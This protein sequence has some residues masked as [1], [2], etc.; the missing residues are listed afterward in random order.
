MHP[1]LWRGEMIIRP[2]PA[3]AQFVFEKGLCS[4]R[5][6]F[7]KRLSISRKGLGGS[8]VR[9]Y[10]DLGSVQSVEHPLIS[11]NIAINYYVESFGKNARYVFRPCFNPGW[12]L[13]GLC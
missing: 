7:D 1:S 6:L 4:I 8:F 3:K 10:A 13:A 2:L 12:V 11:I 9:F 5:N